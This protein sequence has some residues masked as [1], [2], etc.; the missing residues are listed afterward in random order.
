MPK[1]RWTNA[2]K[3]DRLLSHKNKTI[4][5]K[6]IPILL[7]FVSCNSTSSSIERWNAACAQGAQTYAPNAVYFSS[8]LQYVREN[9][10]KLNLNQRKELIAEITKKQDEMTDKTIEIIRQTSE[11]LVRRGTDY[12]DAQLWRELMETSYYLA[13]KYAVDKPN[14]SEL[15]YKR[16]IEDECRLGRKK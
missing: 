12:L 6:K 9:S 15:T 3:I 8:L 13:I 7:L 16:L 11:E 10:P 14:G 4:L 2:K 1:V 5:K